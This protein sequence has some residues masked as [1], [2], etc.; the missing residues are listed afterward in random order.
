MDEIKILE[1]SKKKKVLIYRDFLFKINKTIKSAISGESQSYWK[2]RDESCDAKIKV[3]VDASKLVTII[4]HPKGHNHEPPEPEQLALETR[5]QLMAAFS[6]STTL[7]V[8]KIFKN[9][10]RKRRRE[11]EDKGE[12]DEDQIKD[13]LASYESVRS[14]GYK[15]RQDKR[16]IIP[17]KIEDIK[18]EGKWTQTHSKLHFLLAN[19]GT[20]DKILIFCTINF[21]KHLCKSTCAFMDG[22]FSSTPK[23]FKQIYSIHGVYINEVTKKEQMIPF[24]YALLPGKSR[25]IYCRMFQLIKDMAFNNNLT[26]NPA[27]FQVDFE[28]SVIEAIKVSFPSAKIH[29]C[30][31]HFT[32]AIWKNTQIQGLTIPYQENPLVKKTIKRIGALAFY[33]LNP[34]ARFDIIWDLIRQNAPQDIPG[35]KNL[36]MYAHNNWIKLDARFPRELWN[37]YSNYSHR[38]NNHLEGFH[39]ALNKSFGKHHPNIFEF[40]DGIKDFQ[41][42]F[43]LEIYNLDKGG[44]PPRKRLKYV[45]TNLQLEIATNKFNEGEKSDIQF[46][47]SVGF[48]LK[49]QSQSRII[50]DLSL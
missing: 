35:L 14:L 12:L 27:N 2:C 48:L 21:L 19:D 16:P 37:H 8:G 25:S 17:K 23:Q 42:H 7:P 45:K 47:D 13:A 31:F 11:L 40:I 34:S 4:S 22:T 18:L 43:E 49:Y 15:L 30:L 50:T 32:Q 36:I 6:E 1:L 33:P 5:S 20:S 28:S 41:S 38:T 39:H 10:T 26:F 24:L 29:G 3:K 9:A 46:L 44:N